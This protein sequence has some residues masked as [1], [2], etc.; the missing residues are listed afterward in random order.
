[1]PVWAC[2]EVQ[3]VDVALNGIIVTVRCDGEAVL[4]VGT[5]VGTLRMLDRRR[6][7]LS[8]GRM[9]VLVVP[10]PLR[11]IVNVSVINQ[12]DVVDEVV[13]EKLGVCHEVVDGIPGCGFLDSIVKGATERFH[14]LH[15]YGKRG[16]E[17]QRRKER[18]QRARSEDRERV[19]TEEG[20]KAKKSLSTCVTEKT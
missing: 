16:D 18:K 1:M 10:R 6:R 19:E 5:G 8:E 3:V 11:F 12:W 17:A 13:D 14:H 20:W 2:G 4:P 7:G 15:L 9:Q